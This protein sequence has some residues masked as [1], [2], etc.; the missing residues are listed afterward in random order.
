MSN[1]SFVSNGMFR[2]VEDAEE[3]QTIE[4]FI[5]SLNLPYIGEMKGE[6]Y[7]ISLQDSN[8]FSEVYNLISNKDEL[9]VEEE[10][11]A[12]DGEAR[13]TFYGQFYEVKLDADFDDD[14]YR[15]TIGSR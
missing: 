9:H 7:V 5:D 15:V 12:N 8:E 4:E 13:F 11:T 10:S 14:V 6:E 3:E 2:V 1:D